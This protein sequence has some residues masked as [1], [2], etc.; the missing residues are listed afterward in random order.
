MIILMN[1]EFGL[2]WVFMIF[3]FQDQKGLAEEE[4]WS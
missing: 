3:V 2:L 4:V 1:V